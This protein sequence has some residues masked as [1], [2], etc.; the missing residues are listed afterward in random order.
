MIGKSTN[1]KKSETGVKS[2]V[3]TVATLEIL[4]TDTAKRDFPPSSSTV[5]THNEFQIE[6][7]ATL[8]KNVKRSSIDKL[9]LNE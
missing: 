1:D 3:E 4:S 5:G 2:G 8:A 9:S 6:V 7:K